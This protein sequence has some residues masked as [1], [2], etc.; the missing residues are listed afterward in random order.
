MLKYISGCLLSYETRLIL[1]NAL[2]APPIKHSIPDVIKAG[3]NYTIGANREKGENQCLT[4]W[5]TLTF[6]PSVQDL[7][8]A[9][10]TEKE[11]QALLNWLDETV[12]EVSSQEVLA[13][14]QTH[15]Q[16]PQVLSQRGGGHGL[17]KRTLGMHG[18]GEGK[19]SR[20]NNEGSR[21]EE[22]GGEV[23]QIGS[24]WASATAE[25][26]SVFLAQIAPLLITSYTSCGPF[27]SCFF[28]TVPCFQTSA[29][30]LK[31]LFTFAAHC[32]PLLY[33]TPHTGSP[34]ALIIP[35]S[36]PCCSQTREFQ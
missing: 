18:C 24:D 36:A 20:G 32:S 19:R 34:Y 33:S 8:D 3:W 4:T 10:A 25:V 1:A 9:P 14:S 27:T 13:S 23:W 11:I 35:E 30:W 26:C 7:L 15:G 5:S 6:S 21:W 2:P 28:S 29:D 22:I 31:A 17:G 16:F 12:G